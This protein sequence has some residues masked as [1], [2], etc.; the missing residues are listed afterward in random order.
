MAE[1]K[2]IRIVALPVVTQYRESRLAPVEKR[3]S[4][5]ETICD[6]PGVAAGC[7]PPEQRDEF[8]TH[9][10]GHARKRCRARRNSRHVRIRR[11]MAA[12]RCRADGP[13]QCLEDQLGCARKDR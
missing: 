4:L 12:A 6:R 13:A 9:H 3:S 10:P 5:I 2:W 11:P 1:G 8:A 7:H